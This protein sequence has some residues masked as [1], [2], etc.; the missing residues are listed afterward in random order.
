MNTQAPQ[1]AKTRRIPSVSKIICNG[2]LYC[3]KAKPKNSI[4]T[5]MIAIRIMIAGMIRMY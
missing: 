5:N 3:S 2:D 4:K 1:P